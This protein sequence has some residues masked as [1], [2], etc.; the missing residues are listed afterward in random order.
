MDCHGNKFDRI[1]CNQKLCVCVFLWNFLLPLAKHLIG[2]NPIMSHICAIIIW[3]Q[4]QLVAY[5]F[6]I[7]WKTWIQQRWCAIGILAIVIVTT[8]RERASEESED[9]TSKCNLL[10]TCE[11]EHLLTY[12]YNIMYYMENRMTKKNNQNTRHVVYEHV[13]HDV[14]ITETQRSI[15]IY[16]CMYVCVCVRVTIAN[17]VINQKRQWEPVNNNI[18]YTFNKYINLYI[19]K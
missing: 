12:R 9:E 13:T 11:L 5:E 14:M 6:A 15:Y 18:T 10:Y 7:Y 2:T 3:N 8:A 17:V 4:L 19:S 1:Y 16:V